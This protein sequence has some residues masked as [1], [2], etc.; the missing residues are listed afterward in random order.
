MISGVVNSGPTLGS[1]LGTG[2]T[3]KKKKEIMGILKKQSN[4]IFWV[5]LI[6]HLNM[7]MTMLCFEYLPA[8][9]KKQRSIV[10]FMCEKSFC[11]LW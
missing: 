6:L 1:M 10:Y 4:P 2:L 3:K 9:F 5:P 11:L 8:F 7:K